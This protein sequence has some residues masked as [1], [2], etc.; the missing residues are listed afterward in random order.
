M[1]E[2]HGKVQL[3]F[4]IH[5]TPITKINNQLDNYPKASQHLRWKCEFTRLALGNK[6]MCLDGW[7]K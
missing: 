3:N 6:K 2:W 7:L 5:T 4:Q 1:N